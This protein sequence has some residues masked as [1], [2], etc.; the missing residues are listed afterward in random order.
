MTLDGQS[1]ITSKMGVHIRT[2]QIYSLNTGHLTVMNK[3][4]IA[5]ELKEF[6][7]HLETFI[8]EK[9]A[10]GC[11]YIEEDRLAHEFNWLSLQFNCSEGMSNELVDLYS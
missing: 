3:A 4:G 8:T 5:P 9:R 2:V 6:A 10:F 1:L 11:R 7:S